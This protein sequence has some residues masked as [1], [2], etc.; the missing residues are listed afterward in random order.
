MSRASQNANAVVRSVCDLLAVHK[1][2]HCR[3]NTGAV[4]V[5]KRFFRY[6][7]KGAADVLAIVNLYPMLGG[8]KDID[9]QLVIWVEC[10]AGTGRQSPE[11]FAFQRE[12]EAAG[13]VYLITRDGPDNLL[14]WL[15][16]HGVIR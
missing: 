12:V 1:I 11:Q 10:K 9:P 2:W 3:F 13:H 16:I 15:R 14:A 6:G 5:G 4:S 8:Y 7:V